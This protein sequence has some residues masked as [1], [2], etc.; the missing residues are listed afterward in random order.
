[1]C[2]SAPSMHHAHSNCRAIP[3]VQRDLLSFLLALSFLGLAE[4]LS[5][6]TLTLVKRD[7]Y[8]MHP[9]ASWLGPL[10]KLLVLELFWVYALDILSGTL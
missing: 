9:W 1:M 2:Y 5:S 4:F 6:S 10:T 8:K 7:H 3:Y